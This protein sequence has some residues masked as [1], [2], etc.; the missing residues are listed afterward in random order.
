MCLDF[1]DHPPYSPDLTPSDFHLFPNLIR[2]HTGAYIFTTDDA[3]MDAAGSY[4]TMQDKRP[5]LHG[6]HRGTYCSGPRS[7]V[8]S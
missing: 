7:N 1:I 5:I 4:L 8:W 3:V 6:R 2:H